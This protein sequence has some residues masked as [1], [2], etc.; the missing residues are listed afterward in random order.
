[1][2][3]QIVR[4]LRLNPRPLA[5]MFTDSKPSGALEFDESRWTCIISL[6]DAATAGRTLVI[7]PDAHICMLTGKGRCHP[8]DSAAGPPVYDIPFNYIVLKPLANVN[9]EDSPAVVSML[10]TIDQLSILVQL[11]NYG[12]EKGDAVTL[13][14]ATGCQSAYL[15]PY[16][17]S[18]N[19]PQRAV[20]GM[21]DPYSRRHVPDGLL[22]FSMPWQMFLEMEELVASGVLGKLA[23][24]NH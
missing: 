4:A 10:V 13:P 18:K 6:M 16:L 24:L 3:S 12:R 11:A 2:D 19:D 21:A 5:M 20:V 22:S 8:Q 7:G 15:Y 23:N 1:M 17:E 14:R 9:G